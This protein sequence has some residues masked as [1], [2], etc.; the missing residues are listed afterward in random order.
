[1]RIVPMD[2]RM[3]TPAMTRPFLWKRVASQPDPMM[4]KTWMTPK[5]MLKRMA[6]KLVY[7]KSLTMRLPKV[8]IPPL[9]ILFRQRQPRP[10]RQI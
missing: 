8:E 2:G 10:S 7:P 4:T 6:S 1:M 5:G 3:L 9:A